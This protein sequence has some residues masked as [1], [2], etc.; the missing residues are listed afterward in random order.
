MRKEVFLFAMPWQKASWPSLALGT[1]KGHLAAAGV[2]VRCCH[3]HLECAAAIGWA[4]YDALAECWGAGD[5][6]F[7]AL[8]DPAEA[9]RLTAVAAR[10]LR[11][12]GFDEAARW[13]ETS[14][15]RQLAEL[16]D[17][18]LDRE[19][20]EEWPLVGGTI[21]AMQL[22]ATLYLMRRIRTRGHR[23][24]R[25]LG[26]AGIVGTAGDEVLRRSEDVDLVVSGEGEATLLQI[27]LRHREPGMTA[28]PVPGTVFRAAGKVVRSEPRPPLDLSGSAAPDLDEYYDAARA[29]GI[30]P[31]A[32]KLPFEYSRGC[33]WEHRTEGR[34]RGCS[35]CGLYRN[36]PNHRVK[37]V[38]HVA[39]QIRRG[40]D[41]YRVLE[42]AF[43]DAY[44]PAGYR[45]ELIAALNAE[46]AELRYFTELRCDLTPDTV[47][48][49]SRRA[50]RAQLGVESFSTP[51]LRAIGKGVTGIQSAYS[52]RMCQDWGVETQYN[53]MADIPGIDVETVRSMSRMLPTLFGLTP[54]TATQFY[55]DRNSLA[56]AEPRAHGIDPASLD[57]DPPDWLAPS[58]GDSRIL[59]WVS[60]EPL[61]GSAADAWDEVRDVVARWHAIR[62]AAREAGLP[63]PLSWY[64]GGA[65]LR[66]VDARGD[67]AR[68]Y[69]LDGPLAIVFRACEWM[70]TRKDLESRLAL[71][72]SEIDAAL[73]E[74]VAH[75]LLLNENRHYLLVAARGTRHR[76][77]LP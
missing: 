9:D 70:V 43:V 29:G 8:L 65:W 61:D 20:P 3:F 47:A 31:T 14:A 45:D 72:A 12:A 69:T 62:R 7:G 60:F 5:A 24:L 74:L 73:A 56:F 64:D 42:L 32:L 36:S 53:L 25:I 75:R 51:I 16:A 57:R 26:G 35:F 30:P 21:G 63:S 50:G 18:W 2:E 11:E 59:Q 68:V 52:V 67:H 10:L 33:A 49:L 58:L 38:A 17:G 37:P 66:V 71:S 39:A 34:L 27:A 46:P 15:V 40:A 23:G 28:A 6:L 44:L 19:R 13:S 4:R 54:P 1:L 77:E 41:R 22:T 76:G 55:L 48:L